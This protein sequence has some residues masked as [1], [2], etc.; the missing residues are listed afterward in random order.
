MKRSNEKES[1]KP[2]RADRK[3]A[4]NERRDPSELI[5]EAMEVA[6][7]ALE[8]EKKAAG[9]KE[10]EEKKA[11]ELKETEQKRE[12]EALAEYARIVAELPDKEEA[13]RRLDWLELLLRIRQSEALNI[14]EAALLLG[15][16]VARVRR[17]AFDR[18]LPHYKM[19]GRLFF[20]KSEIT[21]IPAYAQRVPTNEETEAEAVNYSL[22]KNFTKL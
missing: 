8:E 15:L 2:Q 16:S 12:A 13:K 17:L 21:Q 6:D 7:Q 9:L 19:R 3:S 4:R 1:G 10:T 14:V 5:G 20:K 18:V 11:A 22:F